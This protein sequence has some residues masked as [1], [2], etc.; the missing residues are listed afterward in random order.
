MDSSVSSGFT[1]FAI[2][3]SDDMQCRS[4]FSTK[5][6]SLILMICTWT[7]QYHLGL[8]ILLF[9]EVMICIILYTTYLFCRTPSPYYM[10]MYIL[11]YLYIIAEISAYYLQLKCMGGHFFSYIESTVLSDRKV[12]DIYN[13][14]YR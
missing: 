10:Y 8:Q 11:T 2:C 5:A 4:T 6:H 9:V 7:V 1:N 12:S 14:Q 13:E 3:G